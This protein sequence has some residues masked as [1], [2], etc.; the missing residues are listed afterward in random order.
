MYTADGADY[1]H[2][3]MPHAEK[4]VLDECGHFMAID[5]PREIAEHILRFFDRHNDCEVKAL[6]LITDID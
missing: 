5:K 1:F 2:Q 6:T 3:L 4:I